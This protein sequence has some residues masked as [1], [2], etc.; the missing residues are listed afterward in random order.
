[1]PVTWHTLNVTYESVFIVESKV[2]ARKHSSC[3]SCTDKKG[4][5][6]ALER[7]LE[8]SIEN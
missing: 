3:H 1:M 2:G 7:M 4:N 5:G 8:I 6:D